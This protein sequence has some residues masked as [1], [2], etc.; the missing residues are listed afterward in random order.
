[1][2]IETFNKPFACSLCY[3]YTCTDPAN[4]KGLCSKFKLFVNG[5]EHCA[6]FKCKKIIKG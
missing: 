6:D 4:L 3:Y 5:R 1:M 2:I